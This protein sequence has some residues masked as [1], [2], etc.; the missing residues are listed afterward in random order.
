M[1][2]IKSSKHTSAKGLSLDRECN[3]DVV[4]ILVLLKN[5]DHNL[6]SVVDSKNNICDTSLRRA[7]EQ[8]EK[9]K[10]RESSSQSN[11]CFLRIT[12]WNKEWSTA[13]RRNKK[14]RDLPQQ[15]PRSGGESWACWRTRP[16]AWA[17]SRSRGGD[18][19]QSLRGKSR[20]DKVVVRMMVINRT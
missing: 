5:R 8:K 2:C 10:V 16:E 6:G 1:S 13:V 12:K 11:A 20:K 15:E 17:W 14:K 3:L 18:G 9:K 19:F 7:N 4:Q